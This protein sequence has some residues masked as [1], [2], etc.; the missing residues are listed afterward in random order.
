MLLQ[1]NKQFSE[2]LKI[3]ESFLL[4]VQQMMGRLQQLLPRLFVLVTFNFAHTFENRLL[5]NGYNYDLDNVI[6][7]WKEALQSCGPN[8]L[9]IDSEE[10][11][12][13]ISSQNLGT[14]LWAAA[15]DSTRWLS[16]GPILSS[17]SV[18]QYDGAD[19]ALVL[20]PKA[21]RFEWKLKS[22][23]FTSVCKRKSASSTSS[24]PTTFRP[25]SSTTGAEVTETNHPSPVFR[26]MCQEFRPL[27][28]SRR[29]TEAELLSASVRSQ[30]ACAAQCFSH[31]A[32]QIFEF[33]AGTGRCRLL[34]K[35]EKATWVEEQGTTIY[36]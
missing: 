31:P 28:V 15:D 4:Q 26:P 12:E 32:C 35:M 20:R 34:A 23:T 29:Q 6:V 17:F 24:P 19:K 8:L 21:K 33:Q 5:F 18:P 13:W 30:S 3:L 27:G 11:L 16:K 1:R 36:G 14:N 7:N 9:W 10:E 22:A 2:E 25:R